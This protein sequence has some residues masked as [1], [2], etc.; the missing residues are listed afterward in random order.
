MESQPRL[1]WCSVDSR[2]L[3]C[4]KMSQEKVEGKQQK[5]L[6]SEGRRTGSHNV[7]ESCKERESGVEVRVRVIKQGDEWDN[8]QV[9]I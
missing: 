4:I 8:D 7:P 1:R 3:F 2:N 6:Q 5:E 9:S